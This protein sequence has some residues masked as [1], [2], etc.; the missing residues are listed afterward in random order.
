MHVVLYEGRRMK[1]KAFLAAAVVG[2][3]VTTAVAAAAVITGTPGDDVLRGTE[4][5]D[6][7]SA[8]AGNDLDYARDG[9]DEVRAGAGNDGVR[10]ADGPDL[11]YGGRGDDVVAGGDGSDRLYG[12]S[13]S[14]QVMGGDGNDRAAGNRGA[15]A[16]SGNEGN[17]SLFGGWGP[18]RLFG[19]GGND[20]LH[21]LAADGD[22][23]LLNCGPGNDKAWVLRSERLRTQLIG[24]EVVFIVDGLTADLDE[25]ETAD[26]DREADGLGKLVCIARVA[27]RAMQT[28]SPLTL[29]SAGRRRR[30]DRRLQQPRRAPRTGCHRARAPPPRGTR[31]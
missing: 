13:D 3:L 14:D 16:V 9:A 20:E 11:V 31:R 12:G 19:A 29:A 5:A 1:R 23:D 26:A 24:C 10:D 27:A 4:Q 2:V 22:P 21:A 17:D 7:I 6:R 18:D 25:G 28:Y 30:R 8:F 15:D